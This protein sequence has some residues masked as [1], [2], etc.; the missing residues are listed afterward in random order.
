MDGLRNILSWLL[1]LDHVSLDAERLSVQ[2]LRPLDSW[3]WFIIALGALGFAAAV[4]RRGERP[5]RGPPVHGRMPH[6]TV[7]AGGHHDLRA[8]RRA[9]PGSRGAVHRGRDGRRL[10]SMSQIDHYPP[11]QGAR[12]T[13][14][15]AADGPGQTAPTHTGVSRWDVVNGMLR[16]TA[17]GLLPALLEDH[18]VRFFRFSTTASAPTVVRRWPPADDAPLTAGTPTGAATDLAS[19][20]RQVFDACVDTH[21][22]GIIVVSDGQPT[23]AHRVGCRQPAQCRPRDADPCHPDRLRAPARRHRGRERARDTQRL[24]R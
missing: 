22:A 13:A 16:P 10:A 23:P 15:L 24:R 12:L 17:D 2:W 1:D 8:G 3:L 5:R 9:S 18:H 6:G 19:S 21:L 14:L 4:Y 11:D 7:A 20:I